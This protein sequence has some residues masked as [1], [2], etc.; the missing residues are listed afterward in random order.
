[1][2]S[3]T[4][5]YTPAFLRRKAV[6]YLT[7]AV[8]YSMFVLATTAVYARRMRAVRHHALWLNIIHVGSA[9]GL[10]VLFCLGN[11]FRP[12]FPCF[13]NLWGYHALG[14][15]WVFSFIARNLRFLF[16]YEYHQAKLRA[17]ALDTRPV[18]TDG[19]GGC[20]TARLR[21]ATRPAAAPWYDRL[22]F[23]ALV[24]RI[25]WMRKRQLFS[26]PS[27]IRL[28]LGLLCLLFVYLVF[29]Q[30]FSTRFRVAPLATRC[31]L[32]AEYVVVVGIMA[33]HLAVA[34]PLFVF[35]TWGMDEAYG[36]RREVQVEIA[37]GY[38]SY[39]L[40]QAS[41][42]ARA[43]LYPYFAGNMFL[44]AG[45]AAGHVMLVV[46]PLLYERDW[47]Y[48]RRPSVTPSGLEVAPDLFPGRFKKKPSLLPS[49]AAATGLP[50]FLAG[51]VDDATDL[52][53]F[54]AGGFTESL[55]DTAQFERLKLSAAKCFATELILFLEDYQCLKHHTVQATRTPDGAL[56]PAQDHDTNSDPVVRTNPLQ[57]LVALG[58]SPSQFLHKFHRPA[59]QRAAL[60]SRRPNLTDPSV[61]I[62][63]T[64][65]RLAPAAPPGDGGQASDHD[66][67]DD[68][69]TTAEEDNTSEDGPARPRAH[70]PAAVPGSVQPLYYNFYLRYIRPDSDFAVNLPAHLVAPL[71]DAMR[72]RQFSLTMFDLAWRE[73]LNMLFENVYPHYLRQRQRGEC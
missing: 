25:P 37:I 65:A 23:P 7:L 69:A 6:G 13:L 72:D 52:M 27:L 32:A 28:L 60:A 18:R 2:D 12:T 1:M 35:W 44:M 57:R 43:T 36:L 22:S 58:R 5:V 40:F 55:G 47:M 17:P 46:A 56:N 33:V 21:P 66:H 3:E 16:Q 10:S 38:L 4:F 34:C 59:S 62:V 45:L 11:A 26:E 51:R 30:T 64:L 54:G 63:D 20:D 67:S 15:L 49:D 50:A 31:D 61:S 14:F 9:L 8:V 41:F 42:L 53:T 19:P 48:Q 73:V 39:A 71:E 70:D 29:V 68:G 24:Q